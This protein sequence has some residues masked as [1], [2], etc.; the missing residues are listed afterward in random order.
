M[1]SRTT[2][3]RYSM[4]SGR[5]EKDLV[6]FKTDAP[7]ANV[8]DCNIVADPQSGYVYVPTSDALWEGQVPESVVLVYDCNGD[9]PRLVKKISGL[10]HG[11]SGIYPM[12]Q[13]VQ[14]AEDGRNLRQGQL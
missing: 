6:D 12:S 2:L 4:E 3:S 1:A 8:L 5:V 11:V 13:F 10:T 14:A 9:T 7:N